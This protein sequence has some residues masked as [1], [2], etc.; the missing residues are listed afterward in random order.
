MTNNRNLG[1]LRR[2]I[3][4]SIR[5]NKCRAYV[6]IV[7]ICSLI[8]FFQGM[9]FADDDY[10]YIF[11][12]ILSSNISSIDPTKG[13]LVEGILEDLIGISY[14]AMGFKPLT[15]QLLWWIS[16]L[17]LLVLV[18]AYSINDRSISYSDLVLIVAFSRVIDTL[19]VWIGK[20][21]PFLLS[22]LILT[23]N[24]Q[25]TVA[26][27]GIVLAGLSHP[28]L[29]VISTA[30]V[31]LVEVAF[32][33]IWFPAAIVAVLSAALVDAGLF[34]YFFPSLW[35]RPGLVWTRASEIFGNGKHWGLVTLLSSILV[36]FLSIQYF[37]PPLRFVANT[38]TILLALWIF[39]VVVISGVAL[40]HT[41]VACLLTIAPLIVLLRSQNLR[42]DNASVAPD[43]SKPF[44]ILFLSRLVIP[45]IVEFGPIYSNWGLLARVY[46]TL[47]SKSWDR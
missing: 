30:G 39:L 45:H 34:H 31:V 20:F 6:A 11:N 36:P 37:K 21:D 19:S 13:Y 32:V 17:V 7:I 29:A 23:A 14:V 16:G 3:F 10:P 8:V 4:E 24:K 40:D 9:Y 43:F 46:K 2:N 5:G 38:H 1:S 41:R 15:T 35:S 22:F 33:G 25:R 26:L 44:V 28:I 27:V 42:N 12:A 18:V 47:A